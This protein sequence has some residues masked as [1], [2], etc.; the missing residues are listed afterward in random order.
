MY[1]DRNFPTLIGARF[2]DAGKITC[3]FTVRASLISTYIVEGSWP[4]TGLINLNEKIHGFPSG[5]ISNT[6]RNTTSPLSRS[7]I[8]ARPSPGPDLGISRK[9]GRLTPF[10]RAPS[11]EILPVGV[12]DPRSPLIVI[13][14][15]A[16][17]TTPTTPSVTVIEFST[18][19][20]GISCPTAAPFIISGM[21]KGIFKG[22]AFP[23]PG[24]IVVRSITIPPVS[25]PPSDS[26]YTVGEFWPSPGFLKVNDTRYLVLGIDTLWT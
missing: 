17:M 12:C 13:S 16:G 21:K 5:L 11:M 8:M 23:R 7:Q 2:P 20:C 1:V 22:A 6:V 4:A 18:D 25:I 24:T 15:P 19:G 14:V 3:L 26:T 9:S 10:F